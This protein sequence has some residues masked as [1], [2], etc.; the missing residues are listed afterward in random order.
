MPSHWEAT[1]GRAVGYDAGA[2]ETISPPLQVPV[3]SCV[4]PKVIPSE[5][6]DKQW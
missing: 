5:A 3:V 6:I 4:F 1:H 2:Q